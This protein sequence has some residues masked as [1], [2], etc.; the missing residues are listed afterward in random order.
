MSFEV[1]TSSMYVKANYKIHEI[2]YQ[3]N[4][5]L[6]NFMF[7]DLQIKIKNLDFA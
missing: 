5:Y 6:L 7:I 1:F 4:L 2:K 3:Q